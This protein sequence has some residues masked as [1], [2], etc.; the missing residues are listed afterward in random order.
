MSEKIQLRQL[1]LA[2]F[3]Y[4][5]T[6]DCYARLVQWLQLYLKPLHAACSS[7]TRNDPFTES[8]QWSP[9]NLRLVASLAIAYIIMPV[10]KI[11]ITQLKYQNIS[12]I[13]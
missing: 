13:H 6:S 9:E 3:G 8:T 7:L 11:N 2:R 10:I 5:I 4:C 12:Y 1:A